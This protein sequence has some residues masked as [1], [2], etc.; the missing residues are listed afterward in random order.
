MTLS[1]YEEARKEQA[2]S[3]GDLIV[4]IT[5]HKTAKIYGAAHLNINSEIAPMIAG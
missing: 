4:S 3:G 1:K 5:K 2:R